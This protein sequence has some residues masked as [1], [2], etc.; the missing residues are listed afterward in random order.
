M[1]KV[2]AISDAEWQVMRVVWER[3]SPLAASE[4]VEALSGTTDWSAATIKTM[5]NRLVKKGALTYEAQGKRYLYRAKVRREE[6]V[7][8]E[9]RSFL[10]RVFGGAAA[11]MLNHFV[12]DA[13]LTPDE[14]AELKRILSQKE[15]RS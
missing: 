12:R 7:R 2:P 14:V 3:P 10:H 9:G 8:S 5:L 6:C 11:P 15:K 4:V 13:D 1:A